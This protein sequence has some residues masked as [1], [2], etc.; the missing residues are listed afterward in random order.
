MITFSIAIEI[1]FLMI[2]LKS[3][4]MKNYCFINKIVL[5]NNEERLKQS[6][7]LIIFSIYLFSAALYK[8]ILELHKEL[9]F[10]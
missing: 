3:L 2:S 4:Y 9:L 6:F 1:S 5:L 8:L 7:Y 10:H